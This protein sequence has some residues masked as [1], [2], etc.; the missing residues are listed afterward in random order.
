[1][2]RGDRHFATYVSPATFVEAAMDTADGHKF[3][4]G[5]TVT[6]VFVTA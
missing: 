1:M 6:P 4:T 2:R 5:L 3:G